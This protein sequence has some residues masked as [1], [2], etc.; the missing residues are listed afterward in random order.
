MK[1]LLILLYRAFT[2][3][4]MSL[5]LNFLRINYLRCL[6]MKIGKGV[7][8]GRNCDIRIPWN[9]NIGNHVVINKRCVLDG[10][11][12]KLT[13]KDNVDI[14][15]ETNI[16]TCE[17]NPNDINHSSKASDVIIEDHVWIASRVTILPGIII[18]HGAVVACGAVVTKNVTSL[19]IVGGIPAK[20]LSIRSNPCT[21]ILSN[22][23]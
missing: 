9:I 11:G 14:A 3:I 8:I 2:E 18:G 12:A 21:Y 15:Q 10:R 1:R 17:H 13:I 19:T 7:F 20:Q 23:F 22:K 16:W 5:P 6:G 4:I